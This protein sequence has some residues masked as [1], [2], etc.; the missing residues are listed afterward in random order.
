MLVLVFIQVLQLVLVVEVP[1]VTIS[2]SVGVS[3]S[4]AV[5]VIASVGVVVGILRTFHLYE[6]TIQLEF[7]YR[8]LKTNL[9]S[10][11]AIY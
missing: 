6:S 4:V 7:F 10:T 5:N 1:S 8:K 11:L 9:V 2:A 3:A